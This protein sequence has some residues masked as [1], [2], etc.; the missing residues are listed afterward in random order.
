MVEVEGIG[1]LRVDTAYGGDSYVIVD[2][3]Q[4]GVSSDA[5]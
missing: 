4:F 2:A 1:S 3:Q 5:G